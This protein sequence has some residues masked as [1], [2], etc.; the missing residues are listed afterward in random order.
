[1]P[2]RG[3]VGFQSAYRINSL[4]EV[5]KTLREADPLKAFCSTH[6]KELDCYCFT[7]EE[8]LCWKCA[9]K[10]D[11]HL[12]HMLEDVEDI[13]TVCKDG[14]LHIVQPIH[15]HFCGTEEDQERIQNLLAL[16]RHYI[17]G[18]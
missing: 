14:L 2:P 1:M 4:I 11:E 7:C 8:L 17:N 18:G 5:H 6:N 15:A 9:Y 10:S 13:F 3:V 16:F 12:N